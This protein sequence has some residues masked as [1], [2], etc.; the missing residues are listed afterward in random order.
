M[1]V[2]Q[3]NQRNISLIILLLAESTSPSPRLISNQNSAALTAGA[4][5]L[6]IGVAGSLIVSKLIDDAAKC[7]PPAISKLFPL[8]DLLKFNP[9]NP[10]CKAPTRH[11]IHDPGADLD[12][13]KNGHSV[14]A[15]R[16]FTMRISSV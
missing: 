12:H 10:D 11:C 7:K 4:L 14:E 6:G 2:R 9:V 8:P 1:Q 15:K 13:I 5:G 16:P 3:N